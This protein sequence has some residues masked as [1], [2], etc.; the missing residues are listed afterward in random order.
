MRDE[1]IYVGYRAMGPSQKRLTRIVVLAILLLG[2]G[3]GAMLAAS[4]RPAG[5]GQWD[6]SNAVTETGVIR[7]APY[8]FLET[9][10]GPILLAEPGKFGAQERAL[11]LAGREARITGTALTR[12]NRRALEINVLELLGEGVSPEPSFQLASGVLELRGEILDSKCFLGSMK[13][14]DGAMHKSCAM[15][16]LRGGI[17]PLFIGEDSDGRVVDAVL[18]LPELAPIGEDVIGLA[19][20]PVKVR[21]RLA[22]FGSLDLLLLEP[23]SVWRDTD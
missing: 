7:I 5:T 12:G 18:C 1:Q 2:T 17:T 19:G 10:E 22:R 16:C 21:G 15:L 11:E 20:E 6:T 9:P 23:G 3:T 4:L 13:P 8:P 14:G